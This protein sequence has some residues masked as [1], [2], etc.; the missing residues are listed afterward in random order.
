VQKTFPVRAVL[1]LLGVTCFV[2]MPYSVLMPIFADQVLHGGA[3]GYGWLMGATGVGAM[4]GAL[5]L[6]SK[7]SLRGLG[8]WVAIACA[9]FGVSLILFSL[10]RSYWLSAGL[11][12]PV[13]FCMMIQMASSNTLI[14]SMVPDVLRGRVMAVYAMVFMGMAPFGALFAGTLADRVGAPLTVGFGG[15]ACVGGALLFASKLTLFRTE[16]RE[17]IS[18]LRTNA[19]DS[20]E[21]TTPA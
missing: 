11:L 2:A 21:G 8:S 20:S 1:L 3:L 4:F 14:Q 6:A 15:V 12:V 18:G 17:I 10:S 13:G 5:L 9:G 19:T 7:Q 16:A